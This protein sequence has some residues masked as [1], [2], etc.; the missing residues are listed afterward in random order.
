MKHELTTMN[1]S[2]PKVMVLK[3]ASHNKKGEKVQDVKSVCMKRKC[4]NVKNVREVRYC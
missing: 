4:G 1:I 3:Y 2:C